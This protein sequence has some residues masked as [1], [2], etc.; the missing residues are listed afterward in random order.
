ME[1]IFELSTEELK[2][3]GDNL[4]DKI[5]EGLKK[6]KQEILCIPTHITPKSE[7]PNGKVL[8]LDWGGNNFRAAIVEFKNGKPIIL[9]KVSTT[10]NKITTVGCTQ[11]D[12][13]EKM[14]ECISQLTQLDESVKSIGYCFSYPAAARLNGDA[15][16]LNWTKEIDI[17]DM[18]GKPVGE[19]F[20]KYLN[21][22]KDIKTEFTN[23]KVINDTV[24]CLFGG[25]SV[26]G[27]DNYIG[28]IV[29]TGTNMASLMRLNHIEK[30]NSKENWIVPV[31]LESGNFNPPYLTI[32]DGLVDA[33]T[34]NKGEHR[35]EKAISGGYLGEIFKTVFQHDKIK[36]DFDGED[37]SK[38]IKG[39][40]Y[41]YSDE[42]VE[43][44]KYI[45]DRSAKLVAASVAGLVQV[46]AAQD[47]TT[48][49]V[50]LAADGSVF[51]K[52]PDYKDLVE[53]ELKILLPTDV[54]V[55]IIPAMDDPNLIGSAIAALS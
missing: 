1:N 47:P 25:L 35:F 33:M 26:A 55:T 12:L 8:A 43:V 14:A 19:P 29:G 40:T 31:N 50:C 20:V 11:E 17:P 32:I 39:N 46:L 42:K 9:E 16:L 13:F 51:W 3:I 7:I 45:A 30:L 37:L 38:T 34:N 10:I 54:T 2:K 41:N 28:L 4:Q 21:S 44:A 48:K 6:D 15:I 49:K 52:T 24:A 23:I 18:I 53:A 27:F 36:Y 5:E 22:H